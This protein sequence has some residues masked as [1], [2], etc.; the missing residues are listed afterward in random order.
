MFLKFIF[1]FQLQ[2]DTFFP[3]RILRAPWRFRHSGYLPLLII[4]DRLRSLRT[5]LTSKTKKE[6]RK[7]ESLLEESTEDTA[8][9]YFGPSLY[10]YFILFYKSLARNKKGAFHNPIRKN[11]LFSLFFS[12]F[13]SLFSPS[14]PP[15]FSSFFSL[16][17]WKMITT[18]T[19][20]EPQYPP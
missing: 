14:F 10:F 11:P 8:V 17:H 12:F 15:L 4:S 18:S 13:P 7:I 19:P 5:R 20:S 2:N 1:P 16:R 9:S 6:P 3:G